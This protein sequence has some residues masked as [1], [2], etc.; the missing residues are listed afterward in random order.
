M[1][2]IFICA[3][4]RE[5]SRSTAPRTDSSVARHGGSMMSQNTSASM[6]HL[7]DTGSQSRSASASTNNARRQ[8]MTSNRREEL[9]QQLKAVED[10]IAKKRSKMH[11]LSAAKVNAWYTLW[12]TLG[13][14]C[15]FV[16]NSCV[17]A[18]AMWHQICICVDV[19]SHPIATETK[20]Y[21]L[22]LSKAG[23]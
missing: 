23:R 2:I 22:V 20:Q 12:G 19:S 21:N 4:S 6:S 16:F 14:L 7:A 11:W 13:S 17:V 15:V 5:S 18:L 8:S 10:A 9:L 3:E 1:Y